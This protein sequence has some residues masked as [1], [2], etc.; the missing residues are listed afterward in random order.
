MV[1]HTTDINTLAIARLTGLALL[2]LIAFG[3]VRSLTIAS[4]IDINLSADFVATPTT[5]M[6]AEMSLRGMAYLSIVGFGLDVLVTLGLFLLLR[7]TS[8]ILSL[9]CLCMGVTAALMTL[10][11]GVFTMNA[12]LL[13]GNEG[14]ASLGDEAQLTLLTSLQAMTNYTAFHIG[15]IISSLSMAGYFWLFFKSRTIPS[16]L[17]GFGIYASLFVAIAIGLRDFQPFLAST[18]VTALF[19]ICNLIALVALGLYLAIWR[20]RTVTA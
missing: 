5:M 1:D 13:A 19:M 7:S 15:L 9:W 10:L 12:A 16:V 4:G 18:A 14:L 11:G 8:T 2:F 6:D 3:I 20:V 17:A